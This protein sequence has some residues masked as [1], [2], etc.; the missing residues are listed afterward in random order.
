MLKEEQPP[1]RKYTKIRGFYFRL[2]NFNVM[3]LYDRKL[4]PLGFSFPMMLVG[5]LS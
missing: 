5:S 4:P 2:C 3:W 1:S